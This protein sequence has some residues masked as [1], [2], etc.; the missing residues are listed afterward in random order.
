LNADLQRQELTVNTAK[1]GRRQIL[2]IAK[3]VLTYLETLN[4]GDQPDQPLF[5]EACAARQRSQYG[6]TLSNQFYQILL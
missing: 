4:S 2:P 5:P 1:T 3:P 6:G